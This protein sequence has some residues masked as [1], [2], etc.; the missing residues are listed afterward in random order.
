MYDSSLPIVENVQINESYWK[1]VVKAPR[2]AR[3]VKPG[4]FVNV[5]VGDSFEP[6]LR[7]PFSIYRTHHTDKVDLLYEVVGKG[8][9]LMS[10]LQKGDEVQILGPLGSLFSKPKKKE[11]SILVGG[12]VGIVPMIY[13]DEV[14]GADYLIMGYRNAGQVFP[15]SELKNKKS[16]KFVSTNDGSAGKKGFVTDILRPILEKEAARGSKCRV[17]T[18]GPTVM[19][20]AV[21]VMAEEFGMPGELS[22]EETMACGVG[23]CLGCVVKTKDGYETSCQ[24]GPV[25]SF[26]RFEGAVCEGV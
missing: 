7:R 22:V 15:L 8:T 13:W 2:L 5:R 14:Y 9:F 4:H 23:A 6:L 24:K 19:M 18:C 21:K 12:G 3:S 17:Y 25:Y 26:D 16:M 20:N 1:L 11:V 10:R